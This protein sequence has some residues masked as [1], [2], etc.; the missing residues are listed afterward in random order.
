[1]TGKQLGDRGLDR[2]AD[3]DCAVA[4][5]CQETS[6]VGS[7]EFG[8]AL[9]DVRSEA[10]IPKRGDPRS[11]RNDGNLKLLSQGGTQ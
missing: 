4:A 3:L 10:G 5:G 1:M 8:Q 2:G 11:F 6:F 9:G 7:V